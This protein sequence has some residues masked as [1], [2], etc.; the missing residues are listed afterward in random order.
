MPVLVSCKFD[1]T[2][3]IV[4]EKRWRHH[5]P[6]SKSMGMLR[7]NNSVVKSLTRPKFEL[8][9]DFVPVLIICKFDED[10][11][12]GDWENAETL[13]FPLNV[14][15]NFLLPQFW[16]DL[17]EDLMQPFPH[18]KDATDKIWLKLANLSWRYFLFESVD[19]N[20]DGRTMEPCYTINSPCEPSAPVS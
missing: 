2:E 12:K 4:T 20:A 18:P 9:W 8:I 14:N 17:P 6:H 11:I 15:G 5:F 19:D 7:A 3:F 16:S 13:F 10:P 1:E